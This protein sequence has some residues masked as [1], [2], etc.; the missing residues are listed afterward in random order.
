MVDRLKLKFV[1]AILSY[2]WPSAQSS[3]ILGEFILT[4]SSSQ[5]KKSQPR[6]VSAARNKT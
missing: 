5:K 6:S 1:W 2:P 4:V 3:S